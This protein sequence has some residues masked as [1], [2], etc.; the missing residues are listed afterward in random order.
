[1]TANLGSLSG[2]VVLVTG[3]SRGLGRAMAEG[4]ARAGASLVIASRKLD[5]CELA[6]TELADRYGTEALAKAAVVPELLVLE[7][8]AGGR[9]L[10][11]G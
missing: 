3:G 5:A 4:F 7:I 10:G 1:M 2:K 9:K 8:E 11:R 6:A